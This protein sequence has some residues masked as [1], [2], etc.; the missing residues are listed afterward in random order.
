M[1]YNGFRTNPQT[2][3]DI[4]NDLE[5]HRDKDRTKRI[6]QLYRLGLAVER[7]EYVPASSINHSLPRRPIVWDMP[8][9]PSVPPPYSPYR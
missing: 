7:G 8:K 5:A 2:D 3:A 6:K 4:E 1:A 9:K